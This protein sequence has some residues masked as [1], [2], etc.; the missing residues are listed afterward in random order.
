MYLYVGIISVVIG[1]LLSVLGAWDVIPH[2][3]SA[4][5]VIVLFGGLLIGFN[6]IPGPEPDEG[7]PMPVWERMTKIFY[8]PNEVFRNFRSHPA[9]LGAI[10]VAAV[11]TGIYSLAFVNRVTAEVIVNH[12]T[13]RLSESGFIDAKQITVIK[14]Q[15]LEVAESVPARIGGHIST[16]V[17]LSFLAAFFAAVY[18]ICVLAMGGRINYFQALAV[19]AYSIFPVVLI[20][21]L[22]SLLILFLKDPTEIHPILGQQT[23]L[24]DNLGFLVAPSES[25]VL[26][27][28]LAS[29][30]VTGLYGLW[31]AA[32]GLK[33]AGTRVSATTA[34]VAAVIVYLIMLTLGIIL[35]FLFGGLMG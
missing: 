19:A 4:G 20:Q 26:Y 30:S 22:L 8:A 28:L 21:K 14:Q 29:I 7:E 16:F 11:I 13:S 24:V 27:T 10:L 23:L 31:L 33:T 32:T 34:W 15:Q 2:I 3:T 18:L 6:Y 25:P 17:G 5:V 12:T 1:I 35:A 9:W